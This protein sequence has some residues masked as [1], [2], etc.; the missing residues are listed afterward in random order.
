[1]VMEKTFMRMISRNTLLGR[2]FRVV[3]RHADCPILVPQLQQMPLSSQRCFEK[4][5]RVVVDHR[6]SF[7]KAT[8]RKVGEGD[9]RR[10]TEEDR[11]LVHY[12]G[13]KHSITHWITLSQRSPEDDF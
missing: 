10:T 9:E 6:G 12:D 11:Y 1:M 7:Y 2:P 8:I 4:G 13:Q 5:V 3:A